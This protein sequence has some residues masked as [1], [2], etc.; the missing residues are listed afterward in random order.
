MEMSSWLL[1][2]TPTTA[3]LPLHGV[4]SCSYEL[5][6]LPFNK[7]WDLAIEWQPS[8]NVIRL[9]Y[10]GIGTSDLPKFYDISSRYEFVDQ[11]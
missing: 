5:I 2:Q 1:E 3:N 4:F 11:P 8:K 6:S 10:K 9:T 7:L